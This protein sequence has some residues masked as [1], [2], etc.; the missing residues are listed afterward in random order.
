MAAHHLHHGRPVMGSGGIAD[1]AHRFEDRIDRRIVADGLFRAV[2]VIVDGGGHDGSGD[3]QLL[4]GR[5]A[6]HGA[7]PADDDE[8]VHAAAAEE[9][10]GPGLRLLFAEGRA[11]GRFQHR[12]AV[13][14]DAAGISPAKADQIAREKSLIAAEN[15]PGLD[16]PGTGAPDDA[17][18]GGVHAGA[19][20]P[21]VRK[22]RRFILSPLVSVP[23]V[24]FDEFDVVAVNEPRNEERGLC[25]MAVR[26]IEDRVRPGFPGFPLVPHAP[27]EAVHVGIIHGGALP[28]ALRYALGQAEGPGHEEHH[29][30]VLGQEP[31][32]LLRH[33]EIASHGDDSLMVI[34]HVIDDVHFC[35]GK[36]ISGPAFRQ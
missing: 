15:A 36:K 26:R 7:V 21:L 33:G 16:A 12:A 24:T 5:G 10:S 32:L 18:D 17:A 28:D 4:Q 1:A 23:F 30:P 34:A 35:F 25:G 14:D 20:P 11:A 31:E 9:V 29:Q 2:H 19:S 3:A 8:A 6:C 22:A 27:Y 13:M